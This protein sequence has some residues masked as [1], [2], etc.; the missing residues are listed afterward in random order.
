[1]ARAGFGMLVMSQLGSALMLVGF[2]LLYAYGGSFD[3][4]TLHLVAAHMPAL[5]RDA[6]FL[7]CLSGFGV[8]AG[9]APFHVR[10]PLAHPAAPANISALLSGVVINLGFYG[11]A[12]VILGILGGGPVWWGLL[13]TGLGVLSALFG[14]LLCGNRR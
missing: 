4:A 14:M 9:T 10:L 12:R 6:V 5:L 3:F 8:K 2:F 11:A 13:V 7:L 1:V